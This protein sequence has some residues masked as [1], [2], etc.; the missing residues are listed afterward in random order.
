MDK[1]L[2]LDRLNSMPLEERAKQE[3]VSLSCSVMTI[4]F[5]CG[6]IPGL[7]YWFGDSFIFDYYTV[8]PFWGFVIFTIVGI[9]VDIVVSYCFSSYW[10]GYNQLIKQANKDI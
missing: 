6:L 9:I 1:K 3:E 5:L 7:Y 8:S 10:E 4:I 2:E